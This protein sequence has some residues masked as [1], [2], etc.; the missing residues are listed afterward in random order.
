MTTIAEIIESAGGRRKVARALGIGYQ[1]VAVWET[2]GI[3]EKY[4][5]WFIAECRGLTPQTLHEANNIAR[6]TGS[7]K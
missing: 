1:A 3:P 6:R 5:S 4:W 2:R 7:D